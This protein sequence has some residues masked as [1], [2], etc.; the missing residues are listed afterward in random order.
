MRRDGGYHLLLFLYDPGG[1]VWW[2]GQKFNMLLPI[3]V[4]ERHGNAFSIMENFLKQINQYMH[5]TEDNRKMKGR[6]EQK[7]FKI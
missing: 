7:Y 2:L 3:I 6:I 4:F 1:C 5:L